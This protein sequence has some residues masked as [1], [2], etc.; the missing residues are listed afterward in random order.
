[1][2]EFDRIGLADVKQFHAIEADQPYKSF[3]LSMYIMLKVF[4]ATGKDTLLIFEDDVIFKKLDH[5]E[6]AFSQLPPDWDILFLGANITTMVTGIA[7]FPPVKYSPYL[8]RVR[9]AW[10]TH[11]VLYSRKVVEKIVQL[12][13][14]NS[15]EMYDFWLSQNI[16]P[17][18]KCFLINP[19]IAWQRPGKSDLWGGKQTDYTGAFQWG[20]KSMKK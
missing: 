8:H 2:A 12:Y 3:C 11:A 5:V 14:V 13:P 15:F 6:A 10:T 19:M 9:R 16:L 18:N 7:E 4:L 1:M 20:D 17:N